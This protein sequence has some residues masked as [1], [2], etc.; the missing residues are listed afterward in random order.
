MNIIKPFL[1]VLLS[2]FITTVA[3]GQ[4]TTS[5]SGGNST[6]SGGSV[7]YTVGQFV[8]STNSSSS[9]SVAQGVQQPYEISIV[10]A[11]N[12]NSEITLDYKV[13]PNPTGGI[14]K[15]VIKP[16]RDDNIRFSLYDLNGILLQDKKIE[17][18][19]VEIS[20]ESYPASVFFL[21]VLKENMEVKVFKIIKR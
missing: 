3:Q 2:C 9:G 17:N 12:T 1:S 4:S 11:I 15:L 14:F 5:A 19:E 13:Y 8:Y 16:F 10:T 18:E 21:K 20:L 7:S 6:G